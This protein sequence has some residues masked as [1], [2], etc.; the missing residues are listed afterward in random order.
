M[1]VHC[2]QTKKD[3]FKIKRTLGT[4]SGSRAA[5]PG[6]LSG[7]RVCVCVCVGPK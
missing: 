5:D 2:K 7:K 1:N 3:P 6:C 4:V